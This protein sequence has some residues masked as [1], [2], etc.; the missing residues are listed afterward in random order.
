VLKRTLIVLPLSLA[1]GLAGLYLV[2]GEAVFRPETYRVQNL[3]VP[4][5]ILIVIAFLAKWCSPAVRIG[6]LCRGQRIPVLYRSALLVHLTAMSVAALT[7]NNTGV[8]PA[9][10]VALKRLGVP[11]GRGVGV[12]VQVFVLD[13]VFFALAVPASVAYLVYSDMLDLPQGA[14]VVAFATGCLAIVAAV[15]LSRRPQLI[16]RLLLAVARWKLVARFASQLRR[17]ARDYYRSARA[18][19]KMPTSYWLALHLATAAGWFSGFV[20]L[21]LLLKLYGANVGL[22]AI[23]AILSSLTLVSHFVPTPGA[24]GFME[25]AVGLGIGAGGG[26]VAA[27]LL[28]WRLASFYVIFFLGPPAAWLLYL[29]KPATTVGEAADDASPS[30]GRIKSL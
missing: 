21:W 26:N 11:F 19:L 29:S 1:L 28:I 18:F 14:R 3:S 12:A 20:L 17:V 2:V 25:A 5:V 6:L 8:G 9:T 4:L 22:L 10:A 7:P 13:L 16:V 24:A 27:A 15:A 23:L 30:H